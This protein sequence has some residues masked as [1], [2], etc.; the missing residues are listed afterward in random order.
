MALVALYHVVIAKRAPTRAT[1]IRM[2]IVFLVLACFNVWRV[3]RPGLHLRIEEAAIG[4]NLTSPSGEAVPPG[5]SL[6]IIASIWNL[7]TPSIADNWDISIT[8][9][10]EKEAIKPQLAD[11][12]DTHPP[13]TIH[14]GNDTIPLTKL[15]FRQTLNPI[16]TGDKKRGVLVAV[17]NGF[18]KQELGVKGTTIK[19]SC[20]DVSGNLIT[21][22]QAIVG[23]STQQL[24]F[25]GLE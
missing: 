8:V 16:I 25:P 18:T 24:H 23:A 20:Q 1:Y 11:I 12:D 14:F 22:T 3:N 4:D 15:L 21:T 7:G 19:L 2:A 13:A 17:A 10:G 6:I 9:P 5:A